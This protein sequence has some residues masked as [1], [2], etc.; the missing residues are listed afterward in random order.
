MY[1]DT[2]S[3]LRAKYKAEDYLSNAYGRKKKVSTTS[4]QDTDTET[5]P[6]PSSPPRVAREDTPPPSPPP[7]L[8]VETSHPLPLTISSATINVSRKLVD[9][10]QPEPT[11][12]SRKSLP[13]NFNSTNAF[14]E[15]N[16]IS[17]KKWSMGSRT[18]LTPTN[19]SPQRQQRPSEL[20]FAMSSPF[21][22]RTVVLDQADLKNNRKN[23]VFKVNSA[24][25]I[26]MTDNK[27]NTVDTDN[28]DDDVNVK[29]RATIFGPRK[30]AECKVKKKISRKSRADMYIVQFFETFYNCFFS[31]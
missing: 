16:A 2:R 17:E 19:N 10:K 28:V 31:R 1:F 13:D 25:I 4:S 26:N 6:S 14:N 9:L 7:T 29:E 3:T 18:S 15:K 11:F 27:I 21:Q 30:V 8:R 20:S 22:T 5:P 23:Q 12:I 24:E